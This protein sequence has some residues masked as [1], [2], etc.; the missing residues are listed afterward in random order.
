MLRGRLGK[1]LDDGCRRFRV[2][3][4]TVGDATTLVVGIVVQYGPTRPNGT[5]SSTQSAA[6]GIAAGAPAK[7][8]KSGISLGRDILQ[9]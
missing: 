5:T 2:A 9:Q 7:G 4:R 6:T 8:G 3:R 1:R